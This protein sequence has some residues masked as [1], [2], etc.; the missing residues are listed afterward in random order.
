KGKESKEQ[1]TVNVDRIGETEKEP[2]NNPEQ[3]NVIPFNTLLKGSFKDED[4]KDTYT[5]N[6]SSPKEMNISVINE[7]KINMIWVLF[8]ESD[9]KRNVAGESSNENILKG[10]FTAK[11]GKYYLYVYTPNPAMGTYAVK[12]Q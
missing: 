7:C 8:H 1:M 2:N 11:P 5:F 9:M 3:A 6:V 4:Y 10:K 12:V